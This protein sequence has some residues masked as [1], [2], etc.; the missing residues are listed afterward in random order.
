[1]Y[2]QCKV[3]YHLI[4][5]FSDDNVCLTHSNVHIHAC[6]NDGLLG[7]DLTTDE[8]LIQPGLC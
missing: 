1:M 3:C 2:P 4:G 7:K 6:C 8:I 5:S